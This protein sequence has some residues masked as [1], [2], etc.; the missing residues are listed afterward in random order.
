MEGVGTYL[1]FWLVV[2]FDHL[3]REVAQASGGS[4]GA[5]DSV[6]VGLEGR[7]GGGLRGARGVEEGREGDG[8]GGGWV[9]VR[10]ISSG[11]RIEG[12]CKNFRWRKRM[13]RPRTV[14]ADMM[15]Y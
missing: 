7:R 13:R 8:M 15:L 2:P 14:S 10:L 4:E 11:R 5:L 3:R 1:Y 12:Y 9:G 6:Q